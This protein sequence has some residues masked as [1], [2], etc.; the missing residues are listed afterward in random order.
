[1]LEKRIQE[2][3][4]WALVDRFRACADRGGEPYL[5][6]V[7]CHLLR[8]I[9]T[10]HDFATLDDLVAFCDEPAN[11]RTWLPSTTDRMAFSARLA[12]GL[13]QRAATA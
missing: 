2:R 9:L 3:P 6:H 7:A 12:D 8:L 1:M 11:L 4:N 13:R 10:R 5:H